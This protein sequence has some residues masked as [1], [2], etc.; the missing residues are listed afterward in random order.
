[1]MGPSVG[2]DECCQT[3]GHH[4]HGSNGIEGVA[5]KMQSPEGRELALEER[6]VKGERLDGPHE[7]EIHPLLHPHRFEYGSQTIEKGANVL[8]LA[9]R[10]GYINGPHSVGVVGNEGNRL[11]REAKVI[12]GN[13]D[14]AGLGSLQ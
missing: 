7:H 10:Q 11:L 1:M 14:G 3:V 8:K 4:W 9:G 13:V 2:E 12:D 6:A 5:L